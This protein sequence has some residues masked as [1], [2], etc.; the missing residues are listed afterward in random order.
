MPLLDLKFLCE[1]AAIAVV[2]KDGGFACGACRQVLNEFSP[3]ILLIVAKDNGEI[4][5]FLTKQNYH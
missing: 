3:N 1:F 2:T 4:I 5:L